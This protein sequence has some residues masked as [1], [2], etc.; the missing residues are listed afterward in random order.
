MGFSN[1]NLRN[2][3]K[4][5][6][7]VND[8]TAR[9]SAS[10]MKTEEKINLAQLYCG[11]KALGPGFRA[12]IWVQGCA[13]KCPGCLSPEWAEEKPNILVAPNELAKIVLHDPSIT[14]IT[15]SGGEPFL[16]ATQ[17]KEFI[18]EC[19]KIRDID[20][21]CFSGFTLNELRSRTLLVSAEALLS[22]IDVLI[23]GPYVKHLDNDLGLRGSTNQ[24]VIHLT[25][26]MASYDFENCPRTVELHIQKSSDLLM[27]GV[28]SVYIK[29]LLS[30]SRADE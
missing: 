25:N 2:G 22:E 14:G 21:I 16:Q 30:I 12:A 4:Q 13:R 10:A 26:R 18:V 23:D 29:S 1:R 11:T 17:L 5:I 15:L 27:V 24:N 7:E 20:V 3:S 19:K 8:E 28:P 9:N 6:L